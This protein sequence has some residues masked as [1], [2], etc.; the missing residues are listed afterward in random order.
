[1]TSHE[2]KEYIFIYCYNLVAKLAH[3][4]VVDIS[5]SHYIA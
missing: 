5:H 3:L 4:M 2:T 1:M